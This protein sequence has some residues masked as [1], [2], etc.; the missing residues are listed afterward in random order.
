MKCLRKASATS[1]G[2]LLFS[3]AVVGCSTTGDPRS[4]GIFW[5]ES[6]AQARQAEMMQTLQD[7]TVAAKKEEARAGAL[8]SEL[9]SLRAQLSRAQQSRTQ[10]PAP[11]VS[12]PASDAEIQRLKSR[13]NLL[14]RKISTLSN[15]D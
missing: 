5:S 3:C 13:I 9:T 8:R 11:S 7:K 15:A 12:D 2:F 14:E 6:K 10:G 1:L 4:G